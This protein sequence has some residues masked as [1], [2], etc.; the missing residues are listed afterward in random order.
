[1]DPG[2]TASALRALR[3]RGL[4]VLEREKGPA[5]RF[6]L[7]VYVLRP[8][9]GLEITFR[10]RSDPNG[11]TPHLRPPSAVIPGLSPPFM[12]R[13]PTGPPRVNKP[14]LDRACES[15]TSASPSPLP[16]PI[17][18]QQTLELDGGIS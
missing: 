4:L 2:T 17:P 3:K 14:A 10:D 11:Q 9:G 15:Q 13:P 18:G 16:L 6:G 8:V 7:S 12:V 5:G 1:V